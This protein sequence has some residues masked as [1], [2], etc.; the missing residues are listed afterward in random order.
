MRQARATGRFAGKKY[1]WALPVLLIVNGTVG[2]GG[3]YLLD[4]YI[5]HPVQT[6][7][8]L[9]GLIGVGIGQTIFR[10][11][12][13]ALEAEGRGAARSLLQLTQRR[14]VE[15]LNDVAGD[16]VIESV[17]ALDDDDL[18]QLAFDLLNVKVAPDGKVPAATTALLAEE[19]TAASV[20]M[21]GSNRAAGRSRLVGACAREI[22]G[23]RL[24]F[25]F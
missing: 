11:D 25:R 6:E 14:L 5:H 10:A 23:R 4:H 24:T 2:L 13:P 20:Q 19:L 17:R 21:R 22:R 7:W 18:E 15:Y 16:A 9:N 1:W 8:L 3:W 12:P